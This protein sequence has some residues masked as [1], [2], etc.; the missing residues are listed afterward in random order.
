MTKEHREAIEIAKK[1]CLHCREQGVEADGACGWCG[2]PCALASEPRPSVALWPRPDWTVV[3]E[4]ETDRDFYECIAL[5]GVARF[6]PGPTRASVK[7]ISILFDYTV[8]RMAG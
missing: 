5:S 7:E 4:A 1:V 8:Q 6:N 2:S 3:P